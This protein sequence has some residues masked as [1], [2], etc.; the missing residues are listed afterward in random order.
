[1]QGTAD[2]RD[3]RQ[4]VTRA[5]ID[6]VIARLHYGSAVGPDKISYEV[7]KCLHQCL[8]TAL[9]RLFTALFDTS[10]HPVEW[11]TAHCVVIPK[12]GKGSY[13]TANS[14]RPISLLSCFG[15][16]FEAVAARRLVQAAVRC[17]ALA[18]TQMGAHAQH[19]AIDA[20]LCV[21]D[22]FDHS[23]SQIARNMKK[24]SIP[25]RPGMLT[26]NIEGAL[27][28]TH[29]SLLDD[30]LRMRTMP[31][32]LW[33]WVRTFNQDRRLGFGLDGCSEEPQPLRCGLPQ[34][35][36]VSP[37]LFLM[38][39]NAP[40]E[41]ASR[42]G[43]ITD[44]SYVDDINIVVSRPR[45]D[46]VVRTLQGRT[47]Q[48]I[49]RAS[50]LK[51][52]LAPG[53]SEFILGLPATSKYRNH[54]E[55]VP[56]A[57]R[58]TAELTVVG[59]VVA[60]SPAVRSLG[61]TIDDA[62]TFRTH[63]ARAASNGLQVLGSMGFLRRSKWSIPAYIAHHL[64]FTAMLPKMMWA[65]PI[66]WNGK[67][68][69]IE[70]V[71]MTY[72]A[73]ARWITGLPMSTSIGKLLTVA[74]LP[75]LVAYLD[76]LTLRYAIRLRFLP[77]DHVLAPN[78]AYSGTAARADYPSRLRMSTLIHA[79]APSGAVEDRF[80]QVDG[81]IPSARSPHPDKE[82]DPTGIHNKWI[83]TLPDL[84]MLLYTDG[85][86][87]EDGRT[88][89][90]WVA[91]C[92]GDRVA[93][94]VA[95]G[96][97]HLGSRAEVYDAELHAIQEALTALRDS[98]DTT[99]GMAY[100]CVDNQSALDTVVSDASATE[101]SRAAVPVAADLS[102]SEW[103][104]Q[105]IWT[106]AH[107]GITG[108]EAAH[109]EAKSGA[110]ATASPCKNAR[111]TKTWMLAESKRQLRLRWTQE[112]SDARPG[113][114]FPAHLRGYQWADT[115]ALWRLYCRRT[116]TD[117]N[118]ARGP[119]AAEPCPCGD[120]FLSGGHAFI[121]CRLFRRACKR[122]LTTS[123]GRLSRAYVLDP[124]HTQAVITFLQTTGLGYRA[125]LRYEDGEMAG[126]DENEVGADGVDADLR[127]EWELTVEDGEDEFGFGL[128][129]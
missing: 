43:N 6:R 23:L 99:P 92:V 20:L 19:S 83:T 70:P 2:L 18:H 98:I 120:G 63:A 62:L 24:G 66:W 21:L 57:Q 80:C 25:P 36:P 110:A 73:A 111:A 90:G 10:T 9:P 78:A 12:P 5:E 102:R 85:S 44:T 3:E 61:V 39:A 100:V 55:K 75:P 104:I 107:V 119:V 64:V 65:S 52:S 68:G 16:V 38:Y 42:A 31:T 114:R 101:F 84:T 30:V 105:G 17:G 33:N 76:Y 34:G 58:L 89:G 47:D 127:A 116:P 108:N 53:K 32:Y 49:E 113:L 22:P 128:F 103:T 93:R 28:N 27:N 41:R 71:R 51:L 118:P 48:Q 125:K 13:T 87:F 88:G 122:M 74:Q 45:P 77:A 129:E 15:K 46:D 82:T 97:C 1:M 54:T 123:P 69:V 14:Y 35:S 121:E 95:S 8:P 117:W 124:K 60:P 79:L 94:K 40:L 106:P 59:R 91:Y 37:V 86:K 29:P 126:M 50:H 115:R 4:P 26:H 96:R 109:A 7:V 72:H 81:A 112:L 67:N 11:K 56:P